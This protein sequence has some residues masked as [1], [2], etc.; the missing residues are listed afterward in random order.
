MTTSTDPS[1]RL[2]AA[3]YLRKQCKQ[4]LA[5][6]P[7]I[8]QGGD[9]EFIHRA[10]VA[11]RRLRAALRIFGD[12]LPQRPLKGWTKQIRRLTRGL[13]AARDL[14][15]Q[16]D[17]LL[18]ALT[19]VEAPA[20]IP[21]LA[22]LL[23]RTELERGRIQGK[24]LKALDR[25]ERSQ[26]LQDMRKTLKSMLET[27]QGED[28]LQ[29]Q[30]SLHVAAYH[31]GERL[32][33]MLVLEDS[34][35]DPNDCQQHHAM[36]IAAKRLR[37]TMEICRPVCGTRIEASLEVVKQLQTF[38]GEVHD[39]DVWIDQLPQMLEAERQWIVER[40]GHAGPLDQLEP[41]VEYLILRRQQQRA[42][43][44]AELARFWQEHTRQGTWTKLRE[45]LQVAAPSPPEP[46]AET[47]AAEAPASPEPSSTP[48]TGD[49]DVR[50]HP[51]LPDPR[52]AER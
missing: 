18:G 46:A 1:C 10:R 52:T 42:E 8:R 38:L 44:F 34:L 37:Y 36:R 49:G 15:V 4:L 11:S 32:G 6:F 40:Y 45:I 30:G 43:R 41:G 2:L 33:E 22:R 12:C 16:R 19:H 39:C 21:G 7:G 20:H 29:T 17:Y 5:Q 28:P 26:V 50:P 9:V 31:I 27:P 13:G 24:V 51:E 23:V 14:D 48:I 35:E 47:P 3:Q 25:L